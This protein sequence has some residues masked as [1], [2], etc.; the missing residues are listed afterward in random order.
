[1]HAVPTY[2]RILVAVDLTE[3]SVRIAECGR[4][5]AAAL[6]SDLEMV[7]VVEPL[8]LAVPIPPEA[9]TPVLLETQD[10]L[11]QAAQEHLARLA[12]HPALQPV[13]WSV[14][15]GNIKAEILRVARER[16]VDLIVLGNREKHGLA[17]IFG[18]TEDAVL[19][20]APCDVLAV[21]VVA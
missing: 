21:R 15:V 1:V 20:S 9:V 13:R 5:L 2:R 4:V 6:G 10:E 17:V 14:E 16:N 12:A 11:V 3:N 18:P 7:H 19:H 8:P